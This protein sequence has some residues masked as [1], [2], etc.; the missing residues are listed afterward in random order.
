MNLFTRIPSFLS[1]TYFEFLTRKLFITINIS[2]NQ[3]LI[4]LI[5][6]IRY[7]M[8]FKLGIFTEPLAVGLDSSVGQLFGLE[9]VL[10][11]LAATVTLGPGV[12]HLEAAHGGGATL[13]PILPAVATVGVQRVLRLS[14]HVHLLLLLLRHFRD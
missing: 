9:V 7:D 5:Q 4:T 14:R 6:S 10:E 11:D 2:R 1:N 3:T 13:R 8:H 12:V